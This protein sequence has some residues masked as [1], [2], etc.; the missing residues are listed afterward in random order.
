MKIF[1]DFWAY[2]KT[3][4]VGGQQL[5]FSFFDVLGIVLF[6]FPNLAERLVRDETLTRRIGGGIFFLSFLMA[7]F[8]LYRRLI[9]ETS[10]IGENSLLMYPYANPPYN[11]A[12]MRY[13]GPETVKDL[14]VRL[15]YKN[16]AGEKKETEVTEFFPQ[17]DLRMIWHHFKVYVLEPNQV[18]R[19]R[20]VQRKSTLDGK[21][22]VLAS[23][24]GA[25]S[26][27]LVEFREEFNLEE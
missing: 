20:L 22:V 24:T 1:S 14:D 23:F 26:G 16:Q 19:F 9:Q 12:E 18:L 3:V 11:V 25:K 2:L 17:N 7:N 13:V 27:K 5:V 6:F 21:V 4:F 10:E 8:F 15:I